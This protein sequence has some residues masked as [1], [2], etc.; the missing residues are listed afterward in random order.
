MSCKFFFRQK[1]TFWNK[2][3]FLHALSAVLTLTK[4]VKFS[5]LASTFMSQQGAKNS[6]DM[7]LGG[8]KDDVI[9]FLCKSDDFL[10]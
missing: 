4:N 3:R 7:G 10:Y 1:I 5:N 9:G 2:N 8:P 6:F